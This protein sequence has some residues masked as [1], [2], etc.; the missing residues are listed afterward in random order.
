MTL[1]PGLVAQ[2]CCLILAHIRILPNMMGLAQRLYITIRIF[3]KTMIM[4]ESELMTSACSC[5]QE[6]FCHSL[7]TELIFLDFTKFPGREGEALLFSNLI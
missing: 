2:Y 7:I 3:V 4:T 5:S 6:P 1:S